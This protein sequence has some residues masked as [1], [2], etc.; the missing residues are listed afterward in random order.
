ME[1]T[2]TSLRVVRAVAERG[3]FTAAA[4]TLGYT[5]S[6]VSR[7]VASL[8]QAIGVSLFD[9]TPGGARLTVAGRTLMATAST[10]LD[11]LDG[12]VDAVRGARG[13]STVLRLGVF[14]SL[15]PPL[16]P[17]VLE[18]LR[19]RAPHLTL[20]TR[21]GSTP[22]LLRSLR[23]STV[24]LAVL[25]AQPPYAAF[26][27]REPAL[28]LATLLEGELVVA[29]PVDSPLGPDGRATLADLDQVAWID[30]P[31]TSEDPGFGVWPA[32]PGRPRVVHQARDWWSKLTL[33]AAGVGA[34]TVPPY[35]LGSAPAGIRAV[36]IVDGPTV[37]RRA[38]LATLPGHRADR[39]GELIECLRDISEDLLQ[40]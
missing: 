36:R 7:Q 12:A 31:R 28:T 3:S 4:E 17:A 6:A 21:E 8:E 32:L 1:W 2:S 20:V 13:R 24:D 26:D 29:V 14:T 9:R 30:S 16:L 39:L 23:A 34:T 5:Q 37:S 22:S 18:L 40:P 27:D 11:D 25:G 15:G 38:V 10:A 35:V 19:E 33:V